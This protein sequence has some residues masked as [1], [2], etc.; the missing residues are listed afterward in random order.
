MVTAGDDSQL[1]LG[2]LVYETMLLVDASRP[3]ALE[4]VL[5]GFGLAD[6]F[7]RFSLNVLVARRASRNRASRAQDLQ[8]T[9]EQGTWE[10]TAGAGSGGGKG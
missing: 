7:E 4:L 9:A 5:K 2:D 10:V 1:V 8:W 6:T 3:Q